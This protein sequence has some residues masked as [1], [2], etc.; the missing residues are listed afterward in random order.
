MS[1][2]FHGNFHKLRFAVGIVLD[3]AVLVAVVVVVLASVRLKLFHYVV[4]NAFQRHLAVVADVVRG[5]VV[6]HL[7]GR[8]YGNGIPN[9][10]CKRTQYDNHA[11]QHA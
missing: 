2:V 4:V 7:V 5:L 11:K 10:A 9:C 3:V 8:E 6:C 1:A